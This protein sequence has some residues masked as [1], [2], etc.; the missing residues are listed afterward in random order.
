MTV[1]ITKI[2]IAEARAARDPAVL[3]TLGLG[4]CVG[5]CL[6]DRFKRI[7]GMAHIMLPSSI[8]IKNNSNRAKFADTAIE[9]LIKE[10]L[11]LG[12][13]KGRITAKIAGGA[14]MFSFKSANDLMR[15]GERNV[16]AVRRELKKHSVEIVAE[17]VGG[18]YG[19]TIEFYS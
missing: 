11:G 19:R 2:G 10:M 4:S 12:A 17:D 7:I 3:V 1:G 14:Q 6:Y 18:S 13:N 8:E 15:I 9:M 5:V 16:E